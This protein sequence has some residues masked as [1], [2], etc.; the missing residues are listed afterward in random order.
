MHRGVNNICL[1]MID[2]INYTGLWNNLF[3]TTLNINKGKG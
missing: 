2:I 3:H 1:I